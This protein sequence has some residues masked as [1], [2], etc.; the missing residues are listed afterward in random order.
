MHHE[1]CKIQQAVSPLLFRTR[2]TNVIDETIATNE[3]SEVA[4][5]NGVMTHDTYTFSVEHASS[6]LSEHSIDDYMYD[7]NA[8]PSADRMTRRACC[9]CYYSHI[10][11]SLCHIR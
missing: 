10:S 2:P 6:Q 3:R 9:A 11:G 7:V 1:W 4:K 5:N 8:R